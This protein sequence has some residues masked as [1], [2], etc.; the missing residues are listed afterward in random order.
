MLARPRSASITSTRLPV[1]A[2]WIARFAATFD[3][4]TPPLPL[5]T[6]KTLSAGLVSRPS[7]A[8]LRRLSA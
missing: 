6:A 8:R 1:L 3:L 7:A 5:V 4:P 2:T